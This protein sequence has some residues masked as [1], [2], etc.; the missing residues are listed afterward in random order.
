MS[1]EKN[2][3]SSFHFPEA[4][5][6]LQA[7]FNTTLERVKDVGA[8][9]MDIVTEEASVGLAQQLAQELPPDDWNLDPV[10]RMRQYDVSTPTSME[11]KNLTIA[12]L[13]VDSPQRKRI[14]DWKQDAGTANVAVYPAG[15]DLEWHIDDDSAGIVAVLTL[16]NEANF[17]YMGQ[18]KRV[19][20]ILTKPGRLVLV[21]GGSYGAWHSVSQ[22]LRPGERTILSMGSADYSDYEYDGAGAR[23]MMQSLRRARGQ[24]LEAKRKRFGGARVIWD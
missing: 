15:K 24:K 22:P 4:T 8:G 20:A 11:F 21:E 7:D 18:D 16:T 1:A 3:N 6:A 17:Y 2:P 12:L 10:G 9:Y 14:A 19:H 23:A 5:E 13:A